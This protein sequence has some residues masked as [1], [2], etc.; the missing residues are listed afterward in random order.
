MQFAK[1]NYTLNKWETM[2]DDQV[3]YIIDKGIESALGANYAEIKVALGKYF[4]KNVEQVLENIQEAS[5]YDE[6]CPVCHKFVYDDYCSGCGQ[7]LKWD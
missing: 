1:N 6:T 2:S 7:H 5:G 3:G 4:P